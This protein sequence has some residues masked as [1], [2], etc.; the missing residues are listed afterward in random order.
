MVE[1]IAIVAKRIWRRRNRFIF[2]SEFQ[3]P[4]EVLQQAQSVLKERIESNTKNAQVVNEGRRQI[5]EWMPPPA[6]IIKVNWDI[7]TE[8]DDGLIGIGIVL[9]DS[10]GAVIASSRTNRDLKQDPLLAEPVGALQATNFVLIW[11]VKASC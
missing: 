7:A 10:V 2:Q 8:K 9:R 1:E 11:V 4:K 5:S 3:H 6:N